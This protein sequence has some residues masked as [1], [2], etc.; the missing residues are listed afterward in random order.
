M[1]LVFFSDLDI[2][3]GIEQM[4]KDGEQGVNVV[5]RVVRIALEEVEDG[6][7]DR[8]VFQAISLQRKGAEED[9]QDSVERKSSHVFE[10]QASHRSSSVVAT[11]QLSAD[12]GGSDLK[13]WLQGLKN[14]EV[15]A[16]H[17]G[18]GVLNQDTKGECR[19]RT[20]FGIVIVQRLDEQGK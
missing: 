20:D 8:L 17:V 13:E 15:L 1:C 16:T 14:G 4:G 9:R 19:V 11:M 18:V 6:T 5:H 2:R 12:G 3:G 7:E 10:N